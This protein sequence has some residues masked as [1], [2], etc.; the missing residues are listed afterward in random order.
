MRSLIYRPSA[1]IKIL[2]SDGHIHTAKY[3]RGIL[4]LCHR[5]SIKYG[6]RND[7][8]DFVQIAIFTAINHEATFDPSKAGFYT[9]I[10]RPIRSAISAEYGE[11]RTSRKHYAQIA[12]FVRSIEEQT[13][14]TPTVQQIVAGTGLTSWQVMAIYYRRIEPDYDAPDTV[15]VELML[16]KLPDLEREVLVS[17]Y[18]HEIP[19]KEIA[20]YNNLTYAEV[21]E[22]LEAATISLKEVYDEPV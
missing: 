6:R 13:G 9:Y 20:V 22:A 17:H 1:Y 7:Y 16:S 10:E 12:K 8:E 2:R 3:L 18:M 4:S 11:T 5:L 14:Y 19:L 21:E 15:D